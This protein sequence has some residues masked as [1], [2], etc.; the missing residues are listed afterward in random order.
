MKALALVAAGFIGTVFWPA[1]PEAATILYVTDAGGPPLVAA[2]LVSSGQALAVVILRLFG[3]RL[4][5]RWSWFARRWQRLEERHGAR[6][7]RAQLPLAI[8]SGLGG[9]PPVSLTTLMAASIGIRGPAFYV[10]L[11]VARVARFTLVAMFAV[12]LR[13]YVISR[14]LGWSP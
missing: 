10:L 3:E 8:T 7:A 12:S 1:N 13:Q 2:L 6:L 9:V 4:R 11:A 5:G 14:G